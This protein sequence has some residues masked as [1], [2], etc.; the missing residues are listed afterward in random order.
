MDCNLSTISKKNEVPNSQTTVYF[1]PQILLEDPFV[2]GS[3]APS[4]AQAS[5]LV[6]EVRCT[7]EL[8]RLW[9]FGSKRLPENLRFGKEENNTSPKPKTVV[10]HWFLFD[11]WPWPFAKIYLQM[12]PVDFSAFFREGKIR[13]QT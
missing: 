1:W 12:L 4:L 8:S 6:N 9:G 10:P 11:P 2:L 5:R 7:A 13:S 3:N